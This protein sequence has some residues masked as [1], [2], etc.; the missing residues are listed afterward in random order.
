MI[1]NNSINPCLVP[2][3]S[4]IQVH[5]YPEEWYRAEA[6]QRAVTFLTFQKMKDVRLTE[7]ADVTERMLHYIKTGEF[8]L[9][10]DWKPN[11]G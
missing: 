4:R 2:G 9:E 5:L 1:P 11:N 6:M 8:P 10:P 7:V 3:D